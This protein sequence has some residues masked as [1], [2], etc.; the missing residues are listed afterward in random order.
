MWRLVRIGLTAPGRIVQW[1]TPKDIYS[2]PA[3]DYVADFVAHMSPLSVLCARDL[4]EPTDDRPEIVVPADT[5]VR[6]I[7]ERFGRSDVPVV[8]VEENG[9]IIGQISTDRILAKLLD[10][11]G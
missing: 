11:R 4:V 7:M 9:Q 5:D 10:P 1:G 8:G 6:E 3:N 2:D